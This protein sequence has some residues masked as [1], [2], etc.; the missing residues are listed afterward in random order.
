MGGRVAVLADNGPEVIMAFLAVARVG[1]TAIPINPALTASEISAV[2]D[3]LGRN[4]S[5]WRQ[6][7]RARSTHCVSTRA[8][9]RSL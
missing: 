4:C 8:W 1:G 3:D 6:I 2:F 5:S 7:L 9:I